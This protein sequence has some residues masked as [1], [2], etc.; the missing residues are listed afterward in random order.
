MI[1]NQI[2]TI[3]KFFT[4]IQ[5]ERSVQQQ[6]KEDE[7]KEK[8]FFLFFLKPTYLESFVHCFPEWVK[9]QWLSWKT[10]DELLYLQFTRTS[11]DCQ[12][13]IQLSEASWRFMQL[14]VWRLGGQFPPMI[15]KI[16]YSSWADRRT[17]LGVQQ[18]TESKSEAPLTTFCWISEMEPSIACSKQGLIPETARSIDKKKANYYVIKVCIDFRLTSKRRRI[19]KESLSFDKCSPCQDAQLIKNTSQ[20]AWSICNMQQTAQTVRKEVV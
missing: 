8:N 15:P 4:L 12:S 14:A 19:S 1:E 13:I 9:L 20:F 10:V 3:T 17:L 2:S 18:K 5:T 6:Y 7:M 11:S 16:G